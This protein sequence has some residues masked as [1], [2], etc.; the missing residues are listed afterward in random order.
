MFQLNVPKRTSALIQVWVSVLLIAVVVIM[1]FTPIITLETFKNTD[2]IEETLAEFSGAEDIEIPEKVGITAPGLV[3]STMLM[4]DMISALSDSNSS[5]DEKLEALEAKLTSPEGQEAILTA[6]ALMSTIGGV[7]G[8]D[9]D[10]NTDDGKTESDRSG[11]AI[12]TIFNILIVMCVVLGVLGFTLIL[13]VVFIIMALT[14]IITALSKL[15]NPEL[16]AGKIGGKLIGVLSIPLMLMLFQSVLP[17]MSYGFGT[18]AILVIA[19][20]SVLLGTVISRCTTYNEK[21]FMYINLTQGASVLGIVGFLVF[22]FNL[23]KTNIFASFTDGE[24][25]GYMGKLGDIQNT[26]KKAKISVELPS[27]YY[28]DILL[29][30]V[31]VVFVFAAI[32]YLKKA[33]RRLSCTSKSGDNLLANAIMTLPVFVLPTIVKGMKHHYDVS[34]DFTEGL[35]VDKSEATSFLQLSKDESSALALVLVDIIIMIVAEVALIVLKK[36]L[37]KDMTKD[38]MK[39]VVSGEILAVADAPAAEVAP[40]EEAPVAEEAPAEEAPAVE[41]TAE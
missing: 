16:V 6:A 39:R 27:D 37:C 41:E 10:E 31:Y 1:S 3:S 23:I 7:F 35:I 28:A 34:L 14:A 18:V 5:A 13:P 24:I 36:V 25:F 15:K 21:E 9:A 30:V 29:I 4:F 33:A 17:G 22:F 12:K 32:S 2:A 20:L 11:N 8:D 40:V 19:I 26:A 38:E